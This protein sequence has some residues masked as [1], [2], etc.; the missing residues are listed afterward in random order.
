MSHG[1]QHHIHH[2]SPVV[3]ALE[4]R[5]QTSTTTASVAQNTTSD[6]G[7]A[8]LFPFSVA[9]EGVDNSSNYLYA[10]VLI[11]SFCV[12]LV[13]TL[14]LRWAKMLTAQMRQMTVLTN[15]TKQRFWAENRTE[16]WPWLK[17]HLL[18]APLWRTRHNRQMQL[19]EAH[20]IG[21]LPSRGHML[22]LLMF[23]ISNLVFCI[24]LPYDKGSY[25]ILAQL[26]GR[27]GLLAA[28]NIIPTVLF[29][30]RNNPLIRILQTPYD[31]FNLFH[32]WIARIFIIESVVH[33]AAWLANTVNAP[34][35]PGVLNAPTGSWDA[36]RL[37]LTIGPHA[38]SYM[39]GMVGAV[40]LSVILLQ[41]WGP[42]RHAFYETFLFT[43]K[44]FVLL[45][46]I[47]IYL[48]LKLDHLPQWTWLAFSFS[49]W[50]A[51]YVWRLSNILYHNYA[52]GHGWTR[53]TVEA[54]AGEAC[55]VTFDL[56]RPWKP[57]P[58]AHCHIYVPVVS[59]TSSHPFSVA[60]TDV[61]PVRRR[62]MD[63]KLPTMENTTLDKNQELK[64]SVSFVIRSRSGFT[65][66]LFEKASC[67]ENGIF[68]TRGAVEGPYAGH[69]SLNSFGTVLLF[70][71]GVGITH[72][73]GYVRDLMAG[74]RNGTSAARKVILVWSVPNTEC[75]E[76]VRP[77]MDEILKMPGRREV[78][79]IQLFIT[80]PRSRG[81][82]VSSTGSIQ[83]FPGRCN[84]QTIIDREIVERMGAMG[85]SVC[86]PGAFADD[87]R[88]AARRRVNVG[89][90]DFVEEAFTY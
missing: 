65:R 70:A 61:S 9:L 42:L 54:L 44:V 30:L 63:E 10:H 75:L 60:W 40:T 21:T 56:A 25:I 55:R 8:A 85:V 17:E 48:H 5:Q 62:S 36:V 52:F 13:A 84:P 90:L 6:T 39:W 78:L 16:W 24:S 66:Q 45:A 88:R 41:T 34:P 27:A 68:M 37:G 12:L 23:G 82:V 81:E 83:M 79:K 38:A 59:G 22:L 3:A 80:K 46:L 77:W 31:T 47:A 87:V 33:V 19:T 1:H 73:V 67:S 29:A 71:G 32:R 89:V 50:A 76:W 7:F 58:G 4:P 43:H 20:A 15:P 69:D 26:R 74:C 28:L 11:V 49:A 86:G 35:A 57:R 64:G 53:V 2:R 18:Y 72:Q 51:E 14:A